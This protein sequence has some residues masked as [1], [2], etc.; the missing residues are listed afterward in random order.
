MLSF[1]G[2]GGYGFAATVLP[3]WPHR[4]ESKPFLSS[5][6]LCIWLNKSSRLVR[7]APE[8][9]G[10]RSLECSL[11]ECCE[12]QGS[13]L[14][15]SKNVHT[16]ASKRRRL[17]AFPAIGLGHGV[18]RVPVLAPVLVHARVAVDAGTAFQPVPSVVLALCPSVRQVLLHS[19]NNLDLS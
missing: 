11:L 15:Y 5:L 8:S 14:T 13:D 3:A 4:R 19:L 12:A 1:L 18:S 9:R 7:R 16:R 10:E 2:P 17:E 6:N